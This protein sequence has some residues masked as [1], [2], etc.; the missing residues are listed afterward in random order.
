MITWS[1]FHT[2][3][4]PYAAEHLLRGHGG[5]FG[6]QFADLLA[7][8]LAEGDGTRLGAMALFG[9]GGFFPGLRRS[10]SVTESDRDEQGG[11]LA[12]GQ[13]ERGYGKRWA[14]TKLF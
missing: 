12:R 5:L 11:S 10:G 2:F 14:S 13:G 9:G 1:R 7:G 6:A 8:A 3:S 4:G